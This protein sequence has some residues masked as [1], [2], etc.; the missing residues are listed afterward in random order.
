MNVNFFTK[1]IKNKEKPGMKKTSYRVYSTD[2]SLS[3]SFLL[4]SY[5][6]NWIYFE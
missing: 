2:G 5:D 3:V 4:H 1:N 6:L